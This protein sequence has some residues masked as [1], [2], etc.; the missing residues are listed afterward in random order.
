MMNER[1]ELDTSKL[2]APIED[3][4]NYFADIFVPFMKGIFIPSKANPEFLKGG[5][6][7]AGSRGHR[8]DSQG[9]VN[10][11]PKAI[12]SR[13]QDTVVIRKVEADQL[14]AEERKECVRRCIVAS[15]RE[16]ELF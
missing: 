3:V 16:C 14:G 4:Q 12:R 1:W 2:P 9:F 13:S 7:I 15:K 10:T 6:R 5:K 11:S 8:K